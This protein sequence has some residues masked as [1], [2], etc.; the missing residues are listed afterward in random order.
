[1]GVAEV[2]ARVVEVR[3]GSRLGRLWRAWKMRKVQVWC[4]LA[5]TIVEYVREP[6]QG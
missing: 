5:D 2:I 1:M 4:D 6:G 3:V